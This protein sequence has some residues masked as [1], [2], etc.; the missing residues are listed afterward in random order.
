MMVRDGK[1]KKIQTAKGEIL[2]V[3]D[4]VEN[5]SLLSCLL[6]EYGYSVRSVTNGEMALKTLHVQKPDAILLDIKMP[7]MDGYEVC[8]EIKKDENLCDIPVIFL[9]ALNNTADKLKAFACG[10]VDYITK[11]YQIEEIAA[12]LENQ[13]TIHRQ[14]IALQQEIEKRREAEGRRKMRL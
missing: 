2:L 9:S 5:L 11:S 10:G 6:T 8:T 12:R 14:R 4:S 1:I 3:D 7:E 13:L